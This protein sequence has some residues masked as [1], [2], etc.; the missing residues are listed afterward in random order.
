MGG[1]E[2]TVVGL[3]SVHGGQTEAG[4]LFM[5]SDRKEGAGGWK[6]VRLFPQWSSSKDFLS[7]ISLGS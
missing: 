2:G 6:W 3:A 1:K 4:D 5:V 7:A